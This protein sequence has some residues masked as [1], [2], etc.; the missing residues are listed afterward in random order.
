MQTL[1]DT[2]IILDKQVNAW[3]F[4][5]RDIFAE[6]IFLSFTMLGEAVFVI[7]LS[8]IISLL[9]WHWR[10]KWQIIALWVV[11]VGSGVCTQI[12]K[13]I[14]HRAR[15][16]DA[17][18]LEHSASFPS[19]HATIAIAFYGFLAYLLLR[20]IKKY[21]ALIL[22][23]SILVISAIGFSRL[24]LGVHYLSDVLA[25][26]LVGAVWL[27]IGIKVDSSASHRVHMGA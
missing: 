15:P 22:A 14:F 3:F 21:R 26:Y 1:L 27:L 13:L 10:K 5:L 16:S 19:G 25:G 7:I 9:L 6:K 11:V 18:L 23:V 20:E 4:G 8:V 12:A 24:Y 17:L 2:V